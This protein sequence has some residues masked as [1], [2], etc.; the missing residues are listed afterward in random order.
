[1]KHQ[2]T[3][4]TRVAAA[5]FASTLPGL[6]AAAF[7]PAAP[8]L[9]EPPIDAPAGV[10]GSL[11]DEAFFLKLGFSFV[12]GLAVG[13][14]LKVAF[15]IALVTLGVLL[16]GISALQYAGLVDVNWSGLEVHYDTWAEWLSVNGSALLEFMGSNLASGA[17]FLAGLGVGLRL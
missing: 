14:A 7:D 6:G 12:V 4:A 5:A 1:M 10:A 9:A 2:R 11:F 15:K 13:F 17:S 16:L 3:R 8:P